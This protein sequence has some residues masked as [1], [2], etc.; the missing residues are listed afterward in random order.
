MRCA[1]PKRLP[2]LGLAGCSHVMKKAAR[3]FL[4][5]FVAAALT[6]IVSRLM[7]EPNIGLKVWSGISAC[8]LGILLGVCRIVVAFRAFDQ[9]END[10]EQIGAKKR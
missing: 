4:I 5:L 7:A 9:N 2:W 6:H 10:T 3:T 8:V 1:R